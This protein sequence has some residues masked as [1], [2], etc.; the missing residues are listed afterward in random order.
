[1][2]ER[3]SRRERNRNLND[4]DR[5]EQAEDA[6]DDVDEWRR[7]MEARQ[8]RNNAML[9]SILCSLVVASMML[10]VNLAVK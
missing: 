1:M 3:P 10:A 9:I 7:Q 8:A 4:H 2:G 5:I 6:L